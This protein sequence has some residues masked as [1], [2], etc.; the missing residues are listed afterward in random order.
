M[1]IK[2]VGKEMNKKS[3]LSKI[4]NIYFLSFI[5]PLFMT[6]GVIIYRGIYPFGKYSFMFTDMYHQYVPFLTGLWDKLHS[7]ESLAY[8][9]RIGLGTNYASI[10]AYYLASPINWL[11]YFFKRENLMEFMTF[12][13]LFKMALSGLTFCYYLSKHFQKKEFY[14]VWFSVFYAMSGF[15]TAYYWNHMW[16]DVVFMAP[17]VILGLEELIVEGSAIFCA[18]P[19]AY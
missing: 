13:I 19:T 16:L 10:Y 17:L 18:S 7:G 6:L 4:T 3:I 11:C 1:V 9:F 14:M 8:T 15:M 5:L 2:Y 12:V